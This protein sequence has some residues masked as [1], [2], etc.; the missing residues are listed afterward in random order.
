MQSSTVLSPLRTGTTMETKGGEG[1]C[2]EST[3]VTAGTADHTEGSVS[4]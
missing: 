1:P 2:S 3:S 4:A